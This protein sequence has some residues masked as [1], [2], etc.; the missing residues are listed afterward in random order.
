MLI[1][2]KD[3]IVFLLFYF[4]QNID[5]VHVINAL[6]FKKGFQKSHNESHSYCYTM[7]G[8]QGSCRCHLLKDK[9]VTQY[10]T[11][12]ITPLCCIQRS[13]SPHKAASHVLYYDCF[14]ILK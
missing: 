13:I 1:Q 4:F 8:D 5:N 3:S 7:K 9:C 10:D 2:N 11:K 14:F 12:A 6:N